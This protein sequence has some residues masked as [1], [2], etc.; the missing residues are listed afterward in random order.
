MNGAMHL[1]EYIDPCYW[2]LMTFL[3]DPYEILQHKVVAQ[4]EL[5]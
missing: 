4:L 5:Q 2:L 1:V 3:E